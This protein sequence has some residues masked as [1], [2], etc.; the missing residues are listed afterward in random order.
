MT[1]SI[2][3]PWLNRFAWLTAAGTFLL[4]GLGGLVTSHEAG[5]SVPDW[6]TTYG[7]NMFLFPLH[8][9]QGNIFYEHTHRLL[10]S[11]VGFLTTVLAVWLWLREPRA[12]LRSLGVCAFFTVA[13]QGLLGGLRV[14]LLKDQIGIVHATLAQSFFV[15]VSLIA[16]FVSGMGRKLVNRG[17]ASRPSA[18]LRWLAVG[19][20]V[21]ILTQLIF[22]ATM[23][24]QHA[25]LAVPDFP[26]AYGKFWPPMTAAFLEQINAHRVSAEQSKPITAFQ[27]RL[28]MAHRFLALT[29]AI[30][31]ASVA[32]KSR[33]ECGA[34]SILAKLTLAWTGVVCLQVALGAATVWSNKAADIATA[35][36]LLG[37][38]SLLSGTILSLSMSRSDASQPEMANG[39]WTLDPILS[40]RDEAVIPHTV[41]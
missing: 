32:L 2:H 10:A 7:Y 11:L 41:A 15:L 3:H 4:I 22:G 24:H 19:S 31:V 18:P 16:I 23:R 37:A 38:L 26:L 39:D 12:W 35:H 14:T 5:M 17:Q 34:G 36:V 8:L 25:G 1:R 28:H 9:W 21:L 13:L 20:T 40:A 30:L 6:P 27:I 33:R 29:I